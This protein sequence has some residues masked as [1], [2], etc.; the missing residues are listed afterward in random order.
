MVHSLEQIEALI[1]QLKKVIA[2]ADALCEKY[3]PQTQLVHPKFAKSVLNLLDYLALRS[4][5]LRQIQP[6]LASL[7]LSSLGRTE[8]HVYASLTAVLKMLYLLAGKKFDFS[9]SDRVSFEEGYEL[10]R[11]HSSDLL[12][13]TH[14]SK[15]SSSIMVTLPSEAA[16]NEQLIM[17]LMNE[18]TD[19]FRI[20]CAHDSEE[21][22]LKM[23]QNVRRSER[24]FHRKTK[25]MMDLGGPKLRTLA[26]K[27]SQK[28]IRLQEGD[29]LVLH[30][31]DE[32]GA[33][34]QKNQKGNALSIAHIGC[35][36]PDVFKDLRIDEVVSFDDG[37]ILGKITKV[38]EKTVEILI[39]FAKAKGSKLKSD[40]GIN[41]PQSDLKI[42]G[43]TAKDIRDLPFIAHHADIVALSF[44][45]QPSDVAMLLAELDRIHA[46]HL[47]VVLKI[48]TKKGFKN[49]PMILLE[50]MKTYPIGVMIARG[51]LAIETGWER[52]AELQE[53]ML[54]I[55]EAAH[56]PVIWATQ[57]LESVARNGIPSRAEITD[58]AM[59][60][61]AEAVMLNKGE[62]LVEA[63]KM[64]DDILSRMQEH[65][66]K[67]SPQL[68]QLKV[69]SL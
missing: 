4:Y 67:K 58:A 40:K 45:N 25:I 18:G 34:R 43:L 53:E 47:G 27:K 30:H 15:R 8:S 66:H 12:G 55:C 24:I 2:S 37:K 9:A 26:L 33:E 19:V 65:Q 48:E 32:L 38:T 11:H 52:M 51:D 13:H 60:Q 14:Q 17:D 42:T 31:P 44:V 22:W 20:N 21:T 16:E 5:D 10:L 54:W 23:I 49:L 29:K 56:V 61:R 7:G 28:H 57:V 63:T 62:H 35:T 46:R 68:K 64:L 3:R 59:A 39:T 36:L 6:I 1:D 69:S 41:F 50:A